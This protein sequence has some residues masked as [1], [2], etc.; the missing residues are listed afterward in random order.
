M[1][2][3]RI[4]EKKEIMC[5][6]YPY[7]SIHKTFLSTSKFA[8]RTTKQPRKKI[9]RVAWTK[10]NKNPLKELNSPTMFLLVF[11]FFITRHRLLHGLRFLHVLSFLR[12]LRVVFVLRLLMRFRLDPPPTRD[13][14]F[15][16]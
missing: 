7:P 3:Y 12:V 14:L 9:M 15:C 11:L 8:R 10:D 5:D 6:V 4:Y 2:K 13:S 1:N 16:K